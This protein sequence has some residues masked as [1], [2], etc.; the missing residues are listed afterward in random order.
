MS[1][2]EKCRGVLY[3]DHG[4]LTE[5]KQLVISGLGRLP[6]YSMEQLGEREHRTKVTLCREVLSVLDKV[7]PGISLG[8]G[9]IMFELHSSLVSLANMEFKKRQVPPKLLSSL[10]EADKYLKESGRILKFEPSN[11][12]YGPLASS[13][14]S[15]IE[16]LSQY[17]EQVKFM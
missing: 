7:E 11:S 2:M 4:V 15:N 6:G 1:F 5:C 8:R 13:I 10:L 12:P 16:E 3:R 17:I 14:N 9:L